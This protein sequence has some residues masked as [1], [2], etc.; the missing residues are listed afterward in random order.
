MSLCRG[1]FAVVL[2]LQVVAEHSYAQEVFVA[3]DGRTLADENSETRAAFV[4]TFGACADW[5]WVVQHN[6]LIGA[7][8][9]QPVARDGKR[10]DEQPVV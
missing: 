6:V 8:P 7:S 9:L 5:E 1:L 3:H 10:L 2:A 4:A